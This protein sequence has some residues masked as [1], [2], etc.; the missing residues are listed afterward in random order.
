MAALVLLLS[1]NAVF[2]QG[3][4]FTYQGR[5]TDSGLPATN[6]Y[7]MEFRLFDTLVGGAQ[8]GPPVTNSSVQVTD[9][10]FTINLDFGDQFDG[11]SRYLEIAIRPVGSLDPFVVLSPRQPVASTPYAIRS[12]TAGNAGQLQ[13]V[14][15]SGFVQNTTS[16]QSET[17]FN[18][19]GTGTAGILNAATQY[20]LGGSRILSNTGTAN[21]FAGVSAA[22]ANTGTTNS[23]FGAN[24][25]QSNTSGGLNSLFGG[26][27]GSLNTTGSNNSFFGAFAGG[28]N[29]T[30]GSNSFF[31]RNAGLANTT[32]SNGT[33]IGS[34][35]GLS[36]AVEN[37]NTFI[38][39]SSNGAAAITNATAIGS[40][41]AVSQSNSLV[42]GSISGVNGATE[43]VNVGIGTAAPSERLQVAGNGLFT[44]TL[45]GNIV[46]A[47]TQY[48]LAGARI[49]SNAG[50]NNLFAGVGAGTANTTG[51][52]NSFFGTNAGETNSTGHHNSFFGY[53]VGQTNTTG[54]YNSFF[55]LEAGEANVV[56]EHN[57]FFGYRAGFNNVRSDNSFFGSNAGAQNTTGSD[58]SFFGSGAGSGNT[59]GSNNTMVGH[60]A[61]ANFGNLTFAT[62]IGAGAV[63]SFSNSVV[64]GR[65]ED[66]VHLPGELFVTGLV[67]LATLGNAGATDICRNGFNELSTC[68]SSLRYKDRLAPFTAGLELI[69][70]LRP[71]T[72]NWKQSGERD[73][74][75]AAEDV[76]ELEPLLVTR[77]ERGEV[78]GVKYNRLNMVLINAVKQLKADKDETIAALKADNDALKQK[79]K[80]QEERL[81]RLEA[82]MSKVPGKK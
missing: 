51:Y 20:N 6:I 42:L 31:G 61:T 74:G 11:N 45:S 44:G 17:N 62:A 47:T 1:A 38:G 19:S 28:T 78:E 7:E 35:A 65:S 32:G 82:A 9:G 70:R 50:S 72:F 12:A 29:S 67:R 41:A 57:S 48:N 34:N 22:A 55:G 58:N 18:V 49:L 13:G 14:P 8:Q 52:E 33:F 36:N 63:V 59:T 71:I 39:A 15:A 30:G 60:S 37:D 53:Y 43:S 16:Q 66:T 10:G 46:S 81:R 54:S 40:R 3:T 25:G 73:L 5:L 69:N 79:V 80:Q 26:F 56:G 4:T 24:A 68:S 77:N 76:A 23:F 21:L 64:L 2:S 27:S 75:L